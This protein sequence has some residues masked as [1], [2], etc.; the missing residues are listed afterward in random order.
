MQAKTRPIFVG[1]A[2]LPLLLA[3][4]KG[5]EPPLAKANAETNAAVSPT[6]R[7]PPQKSEEKVTSPA[8]PVQDAVEALLKKQAGVLFPKETRLKEMA[9]RE[10]VATLNLTAEFGKISTMGEHTE[11][12]AQKALKTTLA[13][14]PQVQ[15][16]GVQVEGKPFTSEATDW[17]TPFPVRS[18]SGE[19]VSNEGQP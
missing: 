7:T 9:L 11:S 3:G 6:T 12:E 2:V 14:F 18:G 4:C 15:K 1:F 5:G 19:A 16:V 10:G 13:A 17:G 8:T